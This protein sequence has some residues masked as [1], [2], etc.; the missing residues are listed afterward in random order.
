MYRISMST[1]PT[2]SKSENQ[3][4]VNATYKG[5]RKVLVL[6]PTQHFKDLIEAVRSTFKIERTVELDAKK[7]G[8]VIS[9]EE[10]KSLKDLNVN[11]GTE[12]EILQ[13]VPK[14]Q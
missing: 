10:G 4:N 8:A 6:Q 13:A 12:I 14:P 5:E 7:A 3:I 11:T 9:R 1:T 2:P